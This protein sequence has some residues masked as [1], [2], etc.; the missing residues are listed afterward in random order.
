MKEIYF[1]LILLSFVGVVIGA[2]IS[3]KVQTISYLLF[4]VISIAYLYTYFDTDI[5]LPY[6]L[7]LIAGGFAVYT[8]HQKN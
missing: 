5:V 2:F 1:I 6:S 8:N 3:I 7:F 4:A